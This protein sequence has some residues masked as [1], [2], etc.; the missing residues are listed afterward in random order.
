[1]GSISSWRCGRRKFR[2]AFLSGYAARRSC[3]TIASG[4]WSTRRSRRMRCCRRRQ[5]TSTHCSGCGGLAGYWDL[6]AN[7][8]NFTVTLPLIWNVGSALA[9]HDGEAVRQGGPYVNA[10][11]FAS[12]LNLS[13]WLFDQTGRRHGISLTHLSE[14][15]F[16]FL[17]EVQAMPAKTAAEAIWA[18]Y[19]RVGRSDR[20]TF[21]KDWVAPADTRSKAIGNRQAK[22]LA[23]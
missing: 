5:S 18:D 13:D 6:V 9:D 20:P 1:M 16:R 17:T 8:G 3:G 12:F 19:Q 22:H 2:S 4:R 10:S 23:R 7:S 11:P 21:L 15:L 14:L